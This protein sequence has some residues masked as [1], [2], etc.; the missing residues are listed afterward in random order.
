MPLRVLVNPTGFA[1]VSPPLR[2][3]KSVSAGR[4]GGLKSGR[5]FNLE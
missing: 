1:D 2:P 3:E 5:M 4:Y